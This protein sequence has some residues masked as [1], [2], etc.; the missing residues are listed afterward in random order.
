LLI[1][2]NLFETYLAE[3]I[4]ELKHSS[5][6]SPRGTWDNEEVTI[7]FQLDRTLVP[8]SGSQRVKC[9]PRT[10]SPLL[11]QE[12]RLP[13]PDWRESH[14]DPEVGTRGSSWYHLGT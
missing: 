2:N 5:R 11:E 12:G 7:E 1:R 10:S 4:I 6:G 13:F 14:E 9:P 3:N 8:R